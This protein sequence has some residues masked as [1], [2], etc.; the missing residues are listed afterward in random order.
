MLP[1]Q[2]GLVAYWAPYLSGI[3]VL[4]A[5]AMLYNISRNIEEMGEIL[6]RQGGRR[7]GD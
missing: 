6:E 2:S 4:V 1:L 3:T 5:L 7:E